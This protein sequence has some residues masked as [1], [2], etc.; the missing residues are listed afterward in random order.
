[1]LFFIFGNFFRFFLPFFLFVKSY[2]ITTTVFSAFILYAMQSPCFE[3]I[4]FKSN[5]E[6]TLLTNT[7]TGFLITLFLLYCVPPRLSIKVFRCARIRTFSHF[8]RIRSK[9]LYTYICMIH[10]TWSST[11]IFDHKPFDFIYIFRYDETF[12]P[13]VDDPC[14]AKHIQYNVLLSHQI[15]MDTPCVFAKRGSIS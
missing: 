4:L 2:Y 5:A 11:D 12:L 10:I 14:R 7:A 6:K 3:R 1:M 13:Q 8:R 15:Y 9:N